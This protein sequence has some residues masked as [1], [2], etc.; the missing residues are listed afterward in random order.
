MGIVR[1]VEPV[2]LVAGVLFTDDDAAGRAV[3]RLMAQYGS[4]AMTSGTF[5]FTMTGYYE[6]EMGNGLRKLFCCFERPVAPGSLPSVK[7]AA[8]G[9]ERELADL[10]GPEP[11]RRVNIDPGYVTP[12][13]LVLAS[14]KDFSHRVYLG[15]GIYGEVTLRSM[16]GSLTAIDTTYPDYQTPLALDFFNRVRCF[17]RENRTQWIRNTG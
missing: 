7:L 8:N 11:R 16:G 14:T 5:E 13:K 4:L 1:T 9:I 15:E 17:V 10:S 2:A 12:A 6:P 3:E